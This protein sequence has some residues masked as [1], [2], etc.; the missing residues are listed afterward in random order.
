MEESWGRNQWWGI[1]WEEAMVERE[2]SVR[3]MLDADH[4]DEMKQKIDEA[5]KDSGEMWQ[6]RLSK[7]EQRLADFKKDV[8]IQ[9]QQLAKER[10]DLQER[11]NQSD[12]IIKR[13]EALNR[14]EVN[15]IEKDREAEREMQDLKFQKAKKHAIRDLEREQ[16]DALEAVE[17]KYKEIAERRIVVERGKLEEDMNKQ[18]H[19]LQTESEGLITGLEN[20][21]AELKSEKDAL[22]K[23]LQETS[24]KL[25]DTED[26]LYDLQQQTKKKQKDNSVTFWRQ[27][28]SQQKMKSKYE[29]HMDD[30]EK[31]FEE[32]EK[33]LA[34]DMINEQNEM[35][36]AALKLSALLA[37]IEDQRKRAHRILTQFR[38]EELMEKRTLI[39]VL[40]KD[41][42]RLTMEKDSL[43]E[44]R[45]LME[46]EIED[47]PQFPVR[48]TL[49]NFS[50]FLS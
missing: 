40:E 22:S 3:E 45:D 16:N 18:I 1:M 28:I 12:E 23:D 10:N 4:G 50:E 38:T 37:D 30:M 48:E 19:Q 17:Q 36:L 49:S 42:E 29:S 46:E 25:E 5:W 44:Q 11:V 2:R 35:I 41:F 33:I 7:E 26:A 20:A 39:R 9:S 47:V 34:L 32:R 6:K 15:R 14:A 24:T 31:D 21:V 43:E 27:I 13:M 8:A